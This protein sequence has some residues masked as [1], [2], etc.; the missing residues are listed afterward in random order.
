MEPPY[1]SERRRREGPEPDPCMPPGMMTEGEWGRGVSGV[2]GAM[3]DWDRLMGM[4]VLGTVALA[5]VMLDT[6][7]T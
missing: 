6:R 3:A 4:G 5:R 7:F 2:E 1:L